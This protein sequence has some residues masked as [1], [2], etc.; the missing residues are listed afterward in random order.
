[1]TKRSP[2]PE[3][4]PVSQP[5]ETY[6]NEIYL[7][8]LTG[9][10]PE[11]PADLHQLEEAARAVLTPEAFG[12]IAGSAGSGD[13]A[14]EN[15]A[16]LRRW[17]I[18]PRMLTDVSDPSYA[19]QVLGTALPVPM[20][21]AP[22]GVLGIA[23]AG[24][25]SAVA[26]AAAAQ[27]IP[28][29]LST[30]SSTPMEDVAA[31]SGAGPRWYQLYWPQ[32]RA[33]AASFLDR[34]QAAGFT[35]LVVT[36]DTRLLSWRPHDLDQG[37][38]PFLRGIGVQNYLTDPAFRAGLAA[39]VDEDPGAAILHYTEMFADP[40][41]T[42]DDLP[43]LR[44]RWAGPVVLKG[45]LSAADARRAADAG[46]DGV[47]VSNHGGRQ[48]D[49]AIGALDALPPVVAAVGRELAV[50]FDGGIRGGAD[51]LKALAL[52]A[53]AVLIGRPYAYGLGLGGED[54]VRHVLR[55]LRQDFELTMRLSG[56]ARL[57]ELGPDALTRRPG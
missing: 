13:T 16:A 56:Y 22:V 37:Y 38:L 29:I 44:E 41:L 48:V 30:A 39:S 3:R 7:N 19:T 4:P 49:G 12:Y 42:W 15:L 46:V 11:F 57:D 45:I 36:L 47:V 17:R 33:V 31:A 1:M 5:L 14:R 21:L 43:F 26:R 54:G 50:L 8:G 53:R 40:S 51:M 27:G 35:V 28:M 23:H 55:A 34:A 2:C 10:R 9:V 52:G 24:G 20:L 18:V 25:E 32:D 6:Q